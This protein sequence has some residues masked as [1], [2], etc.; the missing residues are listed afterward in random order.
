[1]LVDAVWL[2]PRLENPD[3]RV[4][5]VRAYLGEA[6]RG[7]AEYDTG[8]IPGS[9]FF[10]L[11]TDLATPVPDG[12]RHPLPDM[13]TFVGLLGASGIGPSHHVVVYDQSYGSI[14]A[15]LWWMLRS[16]GHEKVSVLDGGWPAWQSA[17]GPVEIDQRSRPATTYTPTAP[18]TTAWSRRDIE[19]RDDN[20]VLIDARAPERY[21]GE[22]EPIDAIAGR[23]PGA[24]NIPHVSLTTHGSMLTQAKLQ[25]VLQ[26]L[27]ISVAY[28]GS[29][30]TACYVILAHVVAGLPEP[31]LYVGSWSDWSQA[32]MAV[33]TS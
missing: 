8:H 22:V 15:R 21:R 10:D 25:S 14:A 12:A 11:E 28:C 13:A 18:L 9:T 7:R 24:M 1:M 31:G 5:D 6:D 2:I 26:P 33:E 20:V 32:G 17:D 16:L 23:I 3:L 19:E 29:G 30:V 4:V 27:P